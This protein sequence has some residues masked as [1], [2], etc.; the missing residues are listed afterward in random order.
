MESTRQDVPSAPAM[1]ERI[2]TP[3]DFPV[4][5]KVPEWQHLFWGR[6][7]M[8]FPDPVTPLDASLFFEYVFPEGFGRA[9]SAF[10]LPITMATTVLNGYEYQAVLPRARTPEEM[11]ALGHAAQEALTGA[12]GTQIER[13]N[14]EILPEVL[15]HVAAMERMD[16]QSASP[17]QLRAY[18]DET[19]ERLVRIWDL[20][21][22]T[23]IPAH[24]S[25]GLFVDAATDLLG[26]IPDFSPYRLVQ[27]IPSKVTEMGLALWALSR[28]ALASPDV[29]RV[30]D[31]EAASD[32]VPALERTENGRDF[33]SDL[34]TYLDA[35]GQRGNS[36][37]VLS[38]VSWIEDPTPVIKMLK[39]YVGQPDRDLQAEAEALA[40]E[41]ERAIADARAVL[42]SYPEEARAQFEFLLDAALQGT[43]IEEEH[44]YHIDYQPMYR[45]RLLMLEIGRRLTAAGALSEPRDIVFLNLD[46]IRNALTDA[47][48]SSLGNTVEAR[49]EEQARQAA[50]QA[51]PVL[52]TMPPGPPP[53]DPLSRALM[54]FSGTPP[55]PA[56][57]PNAV[58]GAPG[59]PGTVR[60]PARVVR[61]LSEAGRLQR[62][63][64]LVAETTA[65][66]W[67]PYFATVAAI[68]TD[69]GGPLS[70]SAVVA[71]EYRIP[72]VVGTEIGT[73]VIHD[74]QMLEVDGTTGLV[75]IL[76]AE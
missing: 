61:S 64:I 69:T 28:R 46:E 70:H 34:Q 23:V 32:V 42:A 71:R 17:E 50:M 4:A 13:W 36:T 59:S 40:A 75:R 26:D 49:R 10:S 16:L 5:W 15:D 11:E 60:G 30:F 3:P 57:E 31:E 12:I 76:A 27:G 24:T 18:L 35:F 63:D 14:G 19:I 33:L 2:P 45:V 56:Q 38:E 39:D 58:Q 20:H 52:G 22:V 68:V 7:R 74:G 25:V 21:F 66:P 67:T 53:D 65:V 41:R 51:P 72:A 73:S 1:G 48:G 9:A 29:R 8:H 62:G 54:K 44:N 37:L 43:F 55:V 47:P 6:D